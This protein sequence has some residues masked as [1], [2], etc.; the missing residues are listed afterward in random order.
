MQ[1]GFWKVAVIR[2]HRALAAW[3]H[4]VPALFV[5]SI[6][7]GVVLVIVAASLKMRTAAGW[8]GTALGAELTLYAL[9]CAAAA[10]PF[11]RSLNLRSLVLLPFVMAVYHVSYGLGFVLGVLRPVQPRV[12]G[13]APARLF[14]ELTR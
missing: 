14:T 8:I 5:C 13:E 2:K 9:A 4:L 11:A 10:A 7:L 6:L 1:Y 3:R 12:N